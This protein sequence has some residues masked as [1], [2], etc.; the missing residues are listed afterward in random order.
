MPDCEFD[1][2]TLSAST[3]RVMHRGEHH[4]FEFALVDNGSGRRV[5]SRG[6]AIMFGKDGTVA[7][8]NFLADAEVA[9]ARAARDCGFID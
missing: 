9:A 8:W 7:A 1:V 5:V 6:P 3:I 4:I 2:V